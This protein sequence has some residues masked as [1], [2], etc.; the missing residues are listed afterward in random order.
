MAIPIYI[1]IFFSTEL[2]EYLPYVFKDIDH[3]DT[4]RY[5]TNIYIS[6]GVLL[7]SPFTGIAPNVAW[8]I[9]EKYADINYHTGDEGTTPT[10]HNQIFYYL[11]YYGLIGV[12]FLFFLYFKIF[13]SIK[14]SSDKNIA[15]IIGSIFIS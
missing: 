11:R 7:E 8:D 3:G 4:H 13:K 12:A 1:I 9:F 10:H 6:K 14:E 15:Y 5:F 2:N